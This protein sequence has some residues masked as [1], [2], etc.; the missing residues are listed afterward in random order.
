MLMIVRIPDV[1]NCE[2]FTWECNLWTLAAVAMG[3]FLRCPRSKRLV[4][5]AHWSH[6]SDKSGWKR[7][8]KCRRL[9]FSNKLYYCREKRRKTVEISKKPHVLIVLEI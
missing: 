2:T 8:I 1:T 6:S 9:I 4:V 5:V 7:R 3:D